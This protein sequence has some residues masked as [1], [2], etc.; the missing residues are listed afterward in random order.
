MSFVQLAH[1]AQWQPG[2][3]IGKKPPGAVFCHIAFPML[4]RVPYPLIL[5]PMETRLRSLVVSLALLEMV[6]SFATAA[7][8][9]F[10]VVYGPAAATGTPL[11]DGGKVTLGV[12]QTTATQVVFW[13][14]N[15]GTT[16]PAQCALG[17]SA[18][19]SDQSRRG[20]VP[21]AAVAHQHTAIHEAHHVTDALRQGGARAGLVV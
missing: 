6:A 9:A 16:D 2:L 18:G 3:K 13:I 7:G 15:T 19:A 10:Q 4:Q 20:P 8:P 14:K 17:G 12:G 11:T 5:R 1:S 21:V